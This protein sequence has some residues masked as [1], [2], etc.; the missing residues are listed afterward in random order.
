MQ[1]PVSLD[2]PKI[3]RHSWEKRKRKKAIQILLHNSGRRIPFIYMSRSIMPLCFNNF[4]KQFS[5]SNS[6]IKANTTVMKTTWRR[7]TYTMYQYMTFFR[8]R[9]TPVSTVLQKLVRFFIIS[10]PVFLI[11]QLKS[12]KWF[13]QSE[14]TL[15][16]YNPKNFPGEHTSGAL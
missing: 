9:S 3:F 15:G 4:H 12:G 7:A 13:G 6:T 10:M 1:V 11:S 2:E 16:S 8:R 5:R 14:G